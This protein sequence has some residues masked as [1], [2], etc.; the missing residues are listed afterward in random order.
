MP[1]GAAIRS[2]AAPPEIGSLLIAARAAP[3]SS[4]S[5][6]ARDCFPEETS[7]DG[8]IPVPRAHRHTVTATLSRWAS[9]YSSAVS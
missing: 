5:T 4:A 6:A 8:T 1:S 7:G 2:T 9:W 3:A